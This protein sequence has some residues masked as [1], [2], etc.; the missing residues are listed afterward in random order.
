MTFI[1]LVDACRHSSTCDNSGSSS[2]SSSGRCGSSGHHHHHHHHHHQHPTPC[3]TTM[4]W[5]LALKTFRPSILVPN[6][7]HRLSAFRG[8]QTEHREIRVPCDTDRVC[9]VPNKHASLSGCFY[10]VFLCHAL[11]AQ[12]LASIYKIGQN[13]Q[14]AKPWEGTHP[15]TILCLDA[16]I[17]N[18][19]T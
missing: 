10:R 13:L 14:E 6:H 11:R 3:I 5:I 7:Q 15:E 1:R 18:F 9:T 17:H 2:I 12:V 16:C 8:M 4:F 19:H